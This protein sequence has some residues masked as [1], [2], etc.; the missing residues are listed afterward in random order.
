MVEPEDLLDV[1]PVS[2]GVLHRLIQERTGIALGRPQLVRL[3]QASLGNPL[4]ALEMA[5]ALSRLD[6]WPMPGEPLPVPD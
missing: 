3:E 6:R 4:L 5:R 1:G 2:L